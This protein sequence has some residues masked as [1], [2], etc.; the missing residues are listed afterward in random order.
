M[1]CGLSQACFGEFFGD[2]HHRLSP[3]RRLLNRPSVPLVCYLS[4]LTFEGIG[5]HHDFIRVSL[6][7]MIDGFLTGPL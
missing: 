3:F 6:P 5:S 1:D 7:S 2:L 4:M